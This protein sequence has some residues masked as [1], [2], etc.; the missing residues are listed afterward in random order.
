M[1]CLPI[2]GTGYLC[3][4][5]YWRMVYVHD[6]Y[7]QVHD[8]RNPVFNIPHPNNPDFERLFDINNL[9]EV[10]IW[11]LTESETVCEF[12]FVFGV[13][14][15][16]HSTSEPYNR[17]LDYR[18]LTFEPPLDTLPASAFQP[19]LPEAAMNVVEHE[20]QVQPVPEYAVVPSTHAPEP[21][22]VLAQPSVGLVAPMSPQYSPTSQQQLDQLFGPESEGDCDPAYEFGNGGA[23][24]NGYCQQP[25]CTQAYSPTAGTTPC[26]DRAVAA[27]GWL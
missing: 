26:Y 16:L 15:D 24:Y 21:V 2:K 11:V 27:V 17:V 8:K 13:K 4:A 23:G 1:T 14:S 12:P 3:P 25:A 6:T 22:H 20:E 18:R 9:V 7:V 5:Q 19:A 10:P